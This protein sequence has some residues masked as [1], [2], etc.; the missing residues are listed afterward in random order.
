VQRGGVGGDFF[1][2]V[3]GG[4]EFG[5]TGVSHRFDIPIPAEVLVAV[6]V[7]LLYEFVYFAV[8]YIDHVEIIY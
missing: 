7:R 1:S 5:L 6:P 3:G 4:L 8:V 2:E